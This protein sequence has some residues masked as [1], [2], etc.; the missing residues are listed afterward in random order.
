MTIELRPYQLEALDTVMADLKAEPF[1]LLQAATAAGKTIMFS[2][3]IRRWMTEYPAMSIWVM[4]HRQ[5]LVTQAY[6][7]LLKVWPEGSRYLGLAC[8][9]V[10]PVSTVRP[11]TIGS[12]QTLD[13]R[14]WERRVDLL[15]V[16]ECHRIPAVESGGQYHSVVG[17]LKE[18]NPNLRVLGVTATPYRLGHGY[19]YGDD[20][21]AGRTNLFP[22]LNHQIGLDEL[23]AAG[24]LTPIRAKEAADLGAE[25]AAIKLSHGEYDSKELNSLLIRSVHIQSAVD[26]YNKYGEGRSKILIFAA[27]IEHAEKLTDAFSRAGH[28]AATVHSKMH[29]RDRLTTLSSF[30]HGDLKVLVNVGILTEGWDSP[31]VD[32]IMLCRPTMA[33]ALFVQMIGRGTR[34]HPGKNDLLVLDLSGN[35]KRHG[36]PANPVVRKPGSGGGEPPYKSCP[37]CGNLLPVSSLTCGDCGHHWEVRLVD[38]T[39]PAFMNE[40]KL[41]PPGQSHVMSWRG[42]GHV[43]FKG[44]Y[45]LLLELNCV[46][47][48]VVRHYLDIEGQASRYGQ[49]KARV[50]WWQLSGGKNMPQTVRM[51]VDRIEELHIPEFVSLVTENGRR[52]VKGF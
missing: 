15:I 32:L 38:E 44:N 23:T 22:K 17:R 21:K 41:P 4:A 11:V 36:A 37:E 3:I 18:S 39:A 14:S 7:K 12:V 45:M 47:G 29:R 28:S 6:Q 8:A 26:A 35:Y 46:P 51:A 30:D 52:K 48:G 40:V 43:S 34:L 33:P 9:S 20:C 31:A 27:S 5:E 19:I 25:L 13:S 50:L 42:Y 16:D 2:E 49:D 10:G 24:Y 1:V